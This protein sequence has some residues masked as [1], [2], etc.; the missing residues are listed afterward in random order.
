LQFVVVQRAG[1][2]QDVIGYADLPQVMYKSRHLQLPQF[3]GGN[4][5]RRPQ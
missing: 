3:L 5:A 1:L 2:I 4:G